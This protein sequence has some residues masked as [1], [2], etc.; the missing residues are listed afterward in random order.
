MTN[1]A[2]CETN[3][4]KDE[5]FEHALYRQSHRSKVF[6]IIKIVL[7]C[8]ILLGVGTYPLFPASQ[9]RGLELQGNYLLTKTEI[10]NMMDTNVNTPVIFSNEKKLVQNL[11]KS[12]I[13]ESA[14]I[15]WS[16]IKMRLKINEVAAMINYKG[17]TYLSNAKT[18]SEL[19]GEYP[20]FNHD[21]EE[22]NVP[23]FLSNLFGAFTNERKSLFLNNLKVIERDVLNS[24]SY[25]DYR[26]DGSSYV[27]TDGYVLFYF[28]AEDGIY[29]RLAC[30]EENIG[31]FLDNSEESVYR[32]T[33]IMN[34][35]IDKCSDAVIREDIID[36]TIKYR[37]ITCY[38]GKYTDKNGVTY[39]NPCIVDI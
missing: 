21:F 29:N 38:Y 11:E 39:E 12:P 20:D 1:D 23:T 28:L 6:L 32:L 26:G 31:F 8:V 14:E 9:I 17:E 37:S 4:L 34:T 30:K 15:N 3:L 36:N 7:F 19:R 16:P 2:S 35:L 22:E 10:L 33:Q 27:I 24:I 5:D 25:I 13:I 18:I